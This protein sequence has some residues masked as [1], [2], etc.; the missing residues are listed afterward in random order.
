M[1]LRDLPTP[2]AIA[3]LPR[4]LRGYPIPAITPRDAGVSPKFAITGTARTLVC[5]AERRCSICGTPMAPGPVWR[6]IGAAETA[7][8]AEAAANGRT[9]TNQTPSPEPP[10]HRT[11]MLFA[12]AVCPFLARPNARRRLDVEV[13]GRAVARGTARG[14]LDDVGG[15]VAGFSEHRFRYV[16]GEQVGF[17]FSGLM[18]LRTYTLG[19]E[20]LDEV[21]AVIGGDVEAPSPCPPYLLD[22]E[23]AAEAQASAI[24]AQAMARQGGRPARS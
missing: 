23:K 6:V 24:L 9:A 10:G 5:A 7:A 11:C 16:P 21:A 1:D 22:D 17:L 3:A 12:A 18:E 13:F 20:Q 8:L 15:A 14:V 19:A 2:R 4:D